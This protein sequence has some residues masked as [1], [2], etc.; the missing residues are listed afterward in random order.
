MKYP[1]D[2][3]QGNEISKA[4]NINENYALH[5]LRIALRSCVRKECYT[6]VRYTYLVKRFGT[7]RCS[8]AESNELLPYN[9]EHVTM[10]EMEC[11]E[12]THSP[13]K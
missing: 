3:Y 2:N 4:F 13:S 11:D 7:D 8:I 1:D 10:E 5:L 6:N 12:F 9:V